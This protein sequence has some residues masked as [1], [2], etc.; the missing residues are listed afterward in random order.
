MAGLGQLAGGLANI[1][2]G[3]FGNRSRKREAQRQRDFSE[4]MWNRQNAYN[5]PKNQMQ[6]LKDAGLN[7]ALMYGQGTVGNA[8]KALPYQQPQI[9]SVGVNAAQQAAAGGQAS[10]VKSQENLNNANAGFQAIAG[11]VKAGEYGIAKEMS[12][13]QMDNLQSSTNK[14]TQEVENLRS[15]KGLTDQN[16]L[17][18]KTVNQLNKE[19]VKLEKQGFH[20]GNM[21]ATIMKTV[22]NLDMKKPDDRLTA[23]GVIGAYIGSQIFGQFAKGLQSL[24]NKGNRTIIGSQY[25]NK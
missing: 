20:R 19:Y 17:N 12:K 18:Q 15:Q 6:R 23:Q 3:L 25:I 1:V 16:I 22:F 10:L 14:M 8:E 21:I 4:S 9:E 7:P 13:Y 2:G 24:L 5:T 11:A